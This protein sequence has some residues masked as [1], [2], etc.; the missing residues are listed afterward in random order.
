MPF[1]PCRCLLR[2]E[3]EIR[4]GFCESEGSRQAG[5]VRSLVISFPAETKV[6]ASRTNVPQ[7]IPFPKSPITTTTIPRS[8]PPPSPHLPYP[9]PSHPFTS[10]PL[11]TLPHATRQNHHHQTP[12]LPSTHP[13]SSSRPPTPLTIIAQCDCNLQPD[14]PSHKE[15]PHPSPDPFFQPRGL[16]LLPSPSHPQLRA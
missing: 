3:R 8:H 13:G 1:A 7:S 15:A 11:A 10:L 5:P 9:C 6:F 2:R 4:I 12:T 14:K 16:I